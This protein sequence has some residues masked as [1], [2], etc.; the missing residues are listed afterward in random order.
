MMPPP[1]LPGRLTALA[2][3][4]TLLFTPPL[5][6]LFDHPGANGLSWLPLYL[7]AVWGLLILAAALLLESSDED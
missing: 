5:I 2:L 6:G 4:G 1:K 7:F 3:L